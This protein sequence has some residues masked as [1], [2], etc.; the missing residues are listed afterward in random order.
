[1]WS[2]DDNNILKLANFFT[3]V[4][5]EQVEQVTTTLNARLPATLS[6]ET[7]EASET[8]DENTEEAAPTGGPQGEVDLNYQPGNKNSCN[9]FNWTPKGNWT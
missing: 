9:T 1:M 6:A 8:T 5:Q 2:L 7:E 4:S 3:E